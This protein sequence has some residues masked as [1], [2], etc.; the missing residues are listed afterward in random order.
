MCWVNIHVQ[1]LKDWGKFVLPWLK[2][3]I[4]ARGLFFIGA[5]C[6]SILFLK[7]TEKHILSMQ[8]FCAIKMT[9]EMLKS[10]RNDSVVVTDVIL[11]DGKT[12]LLV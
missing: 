9:Q 6:R 4:F 11:Y 12:M 7:E 10:S 8:S 5:P 2:Y 1:S 3:S